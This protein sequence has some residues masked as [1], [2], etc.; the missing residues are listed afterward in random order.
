MGGGGGVQKRG[1]FKN[2]GRTKALGVQKRSAYK[3]MGHT[4]ARDV[5]KRGMLKNAG[6]TKTRGIQKRG[7]YNSTATILNPHH[8]ATTSSH[9]TP[10][11]ILHG[12]PT[13]LDFFPY[14][15]LYSNF[16]IRFF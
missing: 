5:Q 15:I 6:C 8:P 10:K 16:D 13:N 9:E 4:K 11:T 3:S 2:A 12:S 7:A 14:Y 1:A